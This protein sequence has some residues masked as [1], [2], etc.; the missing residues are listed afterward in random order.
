MI[1]AIENAIT[2]TIASTMKISKKIWY[3]SLINLSCDAAIIWCV[4]AKN[5]L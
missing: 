5:L 2:D 3:V 1:A 4:S